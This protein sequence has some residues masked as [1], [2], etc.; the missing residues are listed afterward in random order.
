MGPEKILTHEAKLEP[1]MYSGAVC[2][3]IYYDF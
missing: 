1:D 3:F 2:M